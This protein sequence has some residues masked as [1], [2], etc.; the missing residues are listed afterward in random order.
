MM[1]HT[2]VLLLGSNTS[3]R[4]ETLKNALRSIDRLGRRLSTG[5]AVESAD[6]SRLGSDYLNITAVCSTALSLHDF[7]SELAA[8]EAA[9]GR[10]PS[11]KYTGVMP[12]DIDVV[13]WDGAIVSPEDYER[14]YFCREII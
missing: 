6:I 2:A 13:M 9:A 8:I 1:T 11:S 3:E 4:A 10:L 7:C 14:P 5:P 12:L